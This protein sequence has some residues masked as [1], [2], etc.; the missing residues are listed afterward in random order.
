MEEVAEMMISSI[1]G[2]SGRPITYYQVSKNK[3]NSNKKARRIFNWMAC[4]AACGKEDRVTPTHMYT[5]RCIA[6]L[7]EVVSIDSVGRLR[8][9]KPTSIVISRLFSFAL[10]PLLY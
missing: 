6:S 5:A 10:T 1:S 7:S 9:G 4:V 2:A 3:K 8:E